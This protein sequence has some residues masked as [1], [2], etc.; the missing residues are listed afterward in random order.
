MAL[1]NTS[2]KPAQQ[3]GQ[4]PLRTDGPTLEEFVAAGY[5]AE[6]YPPAG[7]AAVIARTA[8]PDP[9]QQQIQPDAALQAGEPKPVKKF[10]H[11]LNS[12]RLIKSR[13]FQFSF[14]PYQHVG[15]TYMGVYAAEAT[16]QIAALDELVTGKKSA[17][18]E[19]TEEE[20]LDNLK[21]KADVLRSSGQSLIHLEVSASPPQPA[22]VAAPLDSEPAVPPPAPVVENPADALMTG[23]V[24]SEQPGA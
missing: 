20:Y 12:N 7:Y 16:D 18:T 17:V 5:L 14:S 6:N 22:T 3:E 13:G 1:R 10:Y 21:K 19:I 23:K 8:N 2:R 11:A 15:G 9:D 24:E 4:Q